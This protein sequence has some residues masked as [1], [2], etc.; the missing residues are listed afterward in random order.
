VRSQLR[1]APMR[2]SVPAARRWTTELLRRW[3]CAEL[4]DPARLVVSELVGNAVHH[5]RTE[6]DL[7]L[8]LDATVVRVEV[9]DERAGTVTPSRP[10]A[11]AP[12]GRGLE[13]V[14]H[15]SDRWGVDAAAGRKTVWAEWSRPLRV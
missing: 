12:G 2:S 1:L 8:T 4:A 7:C 10:R 14:A 3:G 15:C 13:L 9:G 11:D 6:L 5:A